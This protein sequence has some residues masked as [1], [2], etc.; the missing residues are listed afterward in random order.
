M[1]ERN[2]FKWKAAHHI[3]VYVARSVV[4][5]HDENARRMRDLAPGMLPLER[6]LHVQV[7]V[8]A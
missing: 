8:E 2:L 5:V 3:G 1:A 7:L 4:E 6:C